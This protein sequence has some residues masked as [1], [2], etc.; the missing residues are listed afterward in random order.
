M[1]FGPSGT[2]NGSLDRASRRKMP[3]ARK[4]AITSAGTRR[5]TMVETRVGSVK[6]WPE[7]YASTRD[8]LSSMV[9]G[10][11]TIAAAASASANS[12]WCTPASPA[13]GESGA[14]ALSMTPRSSQ[15]TW[16]QVTLGCSA[17][18]VSSQRSAAAT[19]AGFVGERRTQ[20]DS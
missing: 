8:W 19:T 7:E 20:N 5:P 16:A 11:S 2:R 10:A 1:P 17:T 15:T 9:T 14:A 4:C 18:S 3:R 12:S 13:A 6:S